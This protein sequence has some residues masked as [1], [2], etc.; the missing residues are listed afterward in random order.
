MGVQN[1]QKLEDRSVEWKPK[2]G[3]E[4]PKLQEN[5]DYCEMEKNW[6]VYTGI[7]CFSLDTFP[8]EWKLCE[9]SDF[10]FAV[11]SPTDLCPSPK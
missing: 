9:D 5:K 11:I 2:L 8:L 10:L 1:T 6:P 3:T 4:T 7:R